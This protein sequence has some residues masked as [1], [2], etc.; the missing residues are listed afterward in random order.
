MSSSANVNIT[1]PNK[2]YKF[3]G[4]LF[5]LWDSKVPLLYRKILQPGTFNTYRGK[6]N[7]PKK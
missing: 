5:Y 7:A 4:P 6:S 1:V 2:F 3:R